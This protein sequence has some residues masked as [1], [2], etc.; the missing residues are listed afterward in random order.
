MGRT[1]PT[2][3]GV[4]DDRVL[5]KEKSHFLYTRLPTVIS[6]PVSFTVSGTR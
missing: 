4:D 2:V 3:T 5:T 6:Y 1:C